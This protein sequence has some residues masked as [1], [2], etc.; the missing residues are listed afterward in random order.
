MTTEALGMTSGAAPERSARRGPT[1]F[2]W[3]KHMETTWEYHAAVSISY[4]HLSL[5]RRG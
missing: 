2:P 3:Q 5:S 1:F 4:I